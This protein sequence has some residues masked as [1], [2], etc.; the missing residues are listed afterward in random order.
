MGQNVI[1]WTKEEAILI[2]LAI[3]FQCIVL[4][5]FLL[6]CRFNCVFLLPRKQVYIG[7]K[8]FYLAI[9]SVKIDGLQGASVLHM[10]RFRGYIVMF[11]ALLVASSFS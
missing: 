3:I 7:P 11:L 9:C 1:K 4:V 6:F 10:E 2:I 5:S 8:D